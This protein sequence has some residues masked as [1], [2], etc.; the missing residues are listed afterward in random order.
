MPDLTGLPPWA[1]LAGG[2]TWLLMVLLWVSGAT[3]GS[4]VLFLGTLLCGVMGTAWLVTQTVAGKEPLRATRA[5]VLVVLAAAV[6]V[7]FDPHSGDVFNLPKYTV[8]VIGAL[9][10]AALWAVAS[11][12]YRSGDPPAPRWRN[13]LHWFVGAIVLWTAITAATSLDVH[14]SLLG[15][16]G[17]YDGLYSMTAFAVVMMTAAEAFD[18][19]DVRRALQ[20]FAFAGGAVIVVYALVQLHDTE[21][22]GAPWD[23]IN[24]HAGSFKNEIFSTFGNPNH[25]GGFLAMVLPVVLV[26]GLGS[27]HWVWRGSAIVLLL[28][29]LTELARTSARGA[30]LAAI[31]ALGVIV[32]MLAPEL[33]RKP[34]LTFGTAG[35]VVLVAAV[36]LARFGNRFLRHSLSDL[37]QSGGASS[38]AQRIHI[39]GTAIHIASRYPL[40]GT[41]PDTFALLYPRYQG[42][43]WVKDFGP[44]YLVNGA[45][46]IFMNFLADQGFI[47]LA[48]FAV[49]LVFAGLRSVG[50]WRRLRAVE[51]DEEGEEITTG[52]RSELA[53]RN[54][55]L[56]AAVSASI[57]AYLVQATFNVQQVGLT[58][59][60]WLLIGLLAVVSRAAGVPATAN[61]ARLLS[62]AD[63]EMKVQEPDRAPAPAPVPAPAARWKTG[64]P[65]GRGRG[66]QTG[67]QDWSGHWPTIVTAVVCTVLVVLLAIGAD[68]P[69]RADHDYWAAARSLQQNGSSSSTVVGQSYFTDMGHAMSLNPWEPTYPSYEAA[70]YENVAQHAS[71]A[72][73][74]AA[75]LGDAL[76]LVTRASADQHLGGEYQASEAGIYQELAELQ[77]T[78][79]KA[80]L[81]AAEALARQAVKDNPRNTTYTGLLS[82]IVTAIK[83]ASSTKPAPKT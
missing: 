26:L 71:S 5:A 10:L 30:W 19:A 80:D 40:T 33:R 41:G 81:A 52:S 76:K 60:F 54:R 47:G 69:Y 79:T 57:A 36:T 50:A 9:V 77:P 56:L 24:W 13:G 51:R 7:I 21:V 29:V 70:I 55:L 3:K 8:V 43:V 61:P 16:Y 75:D 72:T 2:L 37:F 78:A 74:A 34:V 38:V 25:L 35:G 49:L 48:L 83:T 64:R 68:M 66:R 63:G 12:H 46:D 32:F 62:L 53:R 31:A 14:V 44:D 11:V 82:K 6:P 45:H 58:F 4:F 27:R 1:L 17:S 28:A 15:N 18:V 73:A 59:L 67:Y 65:S 23:F 42:A 20:A 22:G 39:W